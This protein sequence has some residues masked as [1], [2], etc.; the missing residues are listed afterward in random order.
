LSW[1]TGNIAG[2]LLAESTR[3]IDK[4]EVQEMHMAIDST[5]RV[6]TQPAIVEDDYQSVCAALSETERGRDFLA[7]FARRNRNADTELVLA[8]LN[9]LETSIRA[10]GTALDRLR[11]EMRVLLIAIKLARPE[12]DAASPLNKA[13]KLITLLD[14]LERRIDVLAEGKPV[15]EALPTQEPDA[16]PAT[17]S[18]VPPSDEPELPIPS[19]TSAQLREILLVQTG[20]EEVAFIGDAAGRARTAE[21]DEG[22]TVA[23]PA[24]V[25]AAPVTAAA[26]IS[27]AKTATTLP[28]VDPLAP[29]M[30][31][32]EVE[33]IALFT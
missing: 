24:T 1:E 20:T 3:L 17:L 5:A 4:L 26:D 21:P 10:E 19:P 30:A 32:S 23:P 28:T 16:A 27:A 2:P 11:G 14:M 31:L 33:R 13:A 25:P 6:N 12:I 8:A 9:R 22:E 18:V 29:I 15:G 7:E